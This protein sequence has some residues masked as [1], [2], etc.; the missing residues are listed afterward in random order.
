MLS[1]PTM[2]LRWQVDYSQRG[3]SPHGYRTTEKSQRE[4]EEQS[5]VAMAL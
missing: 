2:C 4:Y 5:L 1:L 3:G